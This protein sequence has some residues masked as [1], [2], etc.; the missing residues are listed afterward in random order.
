MDGHTYICVDGHTYICMY[1]HTYICMYGH[2]VQ[3]IPLAVAGG[4]EERQTSIWSLTLAT[5]AN[6]EHNG[7][8]GEKCSKGAQPC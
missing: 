1:G 5:Y 2:R 8:L 7:T 3:Y 6:T 4:G